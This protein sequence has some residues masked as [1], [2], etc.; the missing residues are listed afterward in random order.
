ML[1]LVDVLSGVL[2]VALV[3]LGVV[4]RRGRRAATAPQPPQE[5]ASWRMPPLA[6]LGRPAWSRGRL[7]AMYALR[8]YLVVAVLLLLV[9]AVQ[10]GTGH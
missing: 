10:I 8:G 7:I 9:K 3:I 4:T 2:V 5:G 6:L 1:T